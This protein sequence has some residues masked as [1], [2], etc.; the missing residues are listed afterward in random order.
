MTSGLACRD[1]SVHVAGRA[2]VHAVTL[3]VPAGRT[4]AVL[5][6]NGAGKSTLLRAVGLLGPHRSTGEVLLDGGPVTRPQMR[7][8]VAAVLQRPILRRGTV[9]ANAASGLRFRGV[10]RRA[11]RERALP[12]LDALG[13]AHLADR[14]AR[15]L[16]G[17]E[18]QRLSIA[19]ALA[20]GSRVLLLDEPFSGLDAATRGDLLADLRA[21][22]DRHG[23]AT[24]LVTHDR[25]EALALAQ[26]TALLVDGRLRHH[27][28]TRFVLEEPRDADTA[29]LLGFTNLLPPSL[30][31]RPDTL[32]ARPEHCRL[33]SALADPGGDVV[34]VEGV[35]RRSVDLGAATRLDVDTPS[36]PLVCLDRDPP[37]TVTLGARVV[38]AVEQHRSLPG[39]PLPLPS[40]TTLS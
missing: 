1:L 7:R 38:V 19:R 39:T 2:L 22:L 4:L 28:P 6:P 8:A 21:A 26:D 25:H 23:A 20:V 14:D 30:T 37:D 3:D 15:T 10:D 29:R 31:G 18:A 16:S 33:L 35:L 34:T 17:G 9:A 11:A 13:I 36:G 12:W 5:G 27:G 24:V 32:A 40:R